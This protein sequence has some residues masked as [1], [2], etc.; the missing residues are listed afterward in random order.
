MKY[1]VSFDKLNKDLTIPVG[2]CNRITP[3]TVFSFNNDILLNDYKFLDKPHK[4]I[5]QDQVSKS[6]TRDD[7]E[8][9]IGRKDYFKVSFLLDGKTYLK[10]H[11]TIRLIL[12]KNEQFVYSFSSEHESYNYSCLHELD[13]SYTPKSSRMNIHFD[14]LAL[15]TKNGMELHNTVKNMAIFDLCDDDTMKNDPYCIKIIKD[16]NYDRLYT[17]CGDNHIIKFLHPDCPPFFKNYLK[18]LLHYYDYNAIM[19]A[20]NS[21]DFQPDVSVSF[22]RKDKE[23]IKIISDGSVALTITI[24]N[25]SFES[26]MGRLCIFTPDGDIQETPVTLDPRK[27]HLLKHTISIKNDLGID[28]GSFLV[29][30]YIFDKD[31][32]CLSIPM[33]KYTYHDAI[34]KSSGNGSIFREGLPSKFC[35]HSISI[36]LN[37][38]I[39]QKYSYGPKN[40]NHAQ[41][42]DRLSK[43]LPPMFI[44]N[45]NSLLLARFVNP[46]RNW[47]GK[48]YIIQVKQ[49]MT[50]YKLLD[51]HDY[52]TN[53][54]MYVR[55][56]YVPEDDEKASYI[57]NPAHSY[58]SVVSKITYDTEKCEEE[59]I[60]EEL[61]ILQQKITG[62]LHNHRER[63]RKYKINQECKLINL[64]KQLCDL[65]KQQRDIKDQIMYLQI[66]LSEL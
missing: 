13:V 46:D 22:D 1:C 3:E 66:H 30:L 34:A 47:M 48:E 25:N 41:I 52:G 31:S 36:D 27:Q 6:I 15:E 64:Q 20:E 45:N 7:I 24:H 65:Q 49:L 59:R 43:D 37:T 5:D 61:N 53:T 40:S 51:N 55:T 9:I 54:S 10:Y 21:G 35:S 32:G 26:Y 63:K 17:M 33:S 14:D 50:H 12:L 38:I 29:R 60:K 58:R 8:K 11:E 16:P 57:C 62:F 19:M 42:R 4:C 2:R 56:D 39:N 44:I 23:I 18:N 28:N